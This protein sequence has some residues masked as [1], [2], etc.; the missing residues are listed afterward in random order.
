MDT[1]NAEIKYGEQGDQSE[2]YQKPKNSPANEV[3]VELADRQCG[4]ATRRVANMALVAR[5][6]QIEG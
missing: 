2:K 3:V 6:I 4:P 5:F 1:L